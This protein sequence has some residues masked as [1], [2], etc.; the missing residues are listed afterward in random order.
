MTETRIDI[1]TSYPSETPSR[2]NLLQGVSQADPSWTVHVH[3]VRKPQLPGESDL[4]SA[5]ER[6]LLTLLFLWTGTKLRWRNDLLVVH[7]TLDT[8]LLEM[9]WGIN[10]AEAVFLSFENVVY[11]P[12]DA[13]YVHDPETAA[14]LFERADLV[15]ATSKAI[16]REAETHTTRDRVAYIPPSVDTEL[17]APGRSRAREFDDDE[18]VLGWVG[19]IEAHEESLGLLVD[20]LESVE[21]DTITVRFLY[22]GSEFPADLKR[23]L[24]ETGVALDLVDPVPHD[25]VPAVMKSF[26]VGLAPMRDTEF[27]RG[28]SSTKVREYMACGVPVIASDVGENPELIPDDG[29]FLVDG[30]TDWQDALETLSDPAVRR[31]MGANAREHVVEN[32]SISV[33]AAEVR[34][35]FQDLL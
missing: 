30:P 16:E 23:R 12:F 6:G 26:D 2:R 8:D 31:E 4:S 35:R 5:V 15:Y 10:V 19:D 27:N 7:K 28:R 1:V 17:F 14:L 32:Y 33:I 24:Q 25:E 22:S 18:L 13:Q 34:S 11:V 3:E 29:G 20:A 9:R 21:T